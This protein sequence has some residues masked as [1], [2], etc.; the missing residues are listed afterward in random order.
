MLLY[1][2]D[3]TNDIVKR[4]VGIGNMVRLVTIASYI[5]ILGAVLSLVGVAL[6]DEAWWIG[7]ISGIIIGY[8]LGSYT[9]S[10]IIVVIEW[11]AQ[12]LVA[13]GEILTALQK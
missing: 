5:I 13:Q 11:M 1:E 4:L 6:L 9:A 3:R 12:L 2:H 7:G 8:G 10:L